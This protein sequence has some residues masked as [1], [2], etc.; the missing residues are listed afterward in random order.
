[1]ER[2]GV[3]VAE[4]QTAINGAARCRGTKVSDARYKAAIYVQQAFGQR[5]IT[6]QYTGQQGMGRE[7]SRQQDMA[8]ARYRTRGTRQRYTYSKAWR[9]RSTGEDS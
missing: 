2:K 8:A 3:E 9:Q 7:V 5:G 1:M 6:Q 4:Y